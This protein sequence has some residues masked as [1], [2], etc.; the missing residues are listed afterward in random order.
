MNTQLDK[1]LSNETNINDLV[2]MIK[3]D[4]YFK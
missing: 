2:T 4:F 1:T 3:G